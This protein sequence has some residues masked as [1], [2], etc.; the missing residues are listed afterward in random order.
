MRRLTRYWLVFPIVTLVTA[1]GC[2]TVTRDTPTRDPFSAAA[3]DEVLR[4]AQVWSATDVPRMDLRAGPSGSGAFAPEE[5]VTC[6]YVQ[7][8]MS[9]KSPKFACAITPDDKVKVKYGHEN[10]EVYSEVAA[11]RLLW[12][13]GFPADRMYPV[14][15]ICRHCPEGFHGQPT[16]EAGTYEFDFA[17]IERRLPGHEVALADREGWTWPELD[18]ISE[19]EGG[20]PK[21]QIDALKLLATMI[22]HTD[23]KSEQQ[24]LLCVDQP[25]H[26]GHACDHPV[27]MIND[28]GQTFGQANAFN[29]DSVGSANFALWSKTPVWADDS[30]CVANI[31]RS[32]T[33]TLDHPRISEE[34]RKF[35]ADL[36]AQLSDR[37]LHDLFDVARFERRESGATHPAAIADW[38]A[39]FK[40]KREEIAARRCDN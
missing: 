9:G 5:I 16:S 20:A 15:V 29:R 36:L 38:V 25:H 11:T 34:G 12:A 37:Q 13:L 40:A 21:A 3:R 7:V 19:E 24:R 6:E 23:S 14:R 27:A 33:G 10:G 35:L 8:Q 1:S 31:K 32:L 17:S 18:I 28:L 30:S 4:R 2:A 26:E 39:A 22:Q